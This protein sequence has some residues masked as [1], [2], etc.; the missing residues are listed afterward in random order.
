M[1]KVTNGGQGFIQNT[2]CCVAP[3]LDEVK[4]ASIMGIYMRSTCPN[5]CHFLHGMLCCLVPLGTGCT[6]PVLYQYAISGCTNIAI[7]Y[8]TAYRYCNRMVLIQ[9]P[10]QDGE[11]C[12]ANLQIDYDYDQ[13]HLNAS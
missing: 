4:K 2:K 7:P 11:P 1:Q 10:Y 5:I 3:L 12:S 6:I 13:F 9:N 8:Q